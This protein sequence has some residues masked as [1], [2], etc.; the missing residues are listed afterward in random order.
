MSDDEVLDDAAIVLSSS[1]DHDDGTDALSPNQSKK[2]GRAAN[3]RRRPSVLWAFFANDPDPHKLK[4]AEC[5]HFNTR[6][7]HHKKSESAKT[8]LNKC[9]A[10]RQL[11]NGTN[12]DVRP[13]WYV[14]NKK[15]IMK[16][17]SSEGKVPAS[18][19]HALLCRRGVVPVH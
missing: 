5:K 7:N 14:P 10:F 15:Q 8:H 16:S 1:E 18:H 17:N 11:M 19:G 6:I 2:R 12:V 9:A 4:S 13:S 3:A